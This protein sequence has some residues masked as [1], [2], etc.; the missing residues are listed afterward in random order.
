LGVTFPPNKDPVPPAPPIN[1]YGFWLFSY[2][3]NISNT[4]LLYTNKS[5]EI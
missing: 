3:P 5:S 4:I 1:D 2:A